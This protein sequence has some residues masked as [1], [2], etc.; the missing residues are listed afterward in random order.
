M[1][2]QKDLQNHLCTTLRTLQI[3]LNEN[4]PINLK[5]ECCYLIL[6]TTRRKTTEVTEK[7]DKNTPFIQK[8]YLFNSIVVV[9]NRANILVAVLE[10][11]YIGIYSYL[12]FPC[13]KAT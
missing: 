9:T 8:D 7:I 6:H 11:L 3:S 4:I 10:F 5:F 2:V 13:P 1:W 12:F